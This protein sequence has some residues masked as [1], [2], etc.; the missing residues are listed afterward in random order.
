MPAN[1]L[2]GSVGFVSPP[3]TLGVHYVKQFP[4]RRQCLLAPHGPSDGSH[5]AAARHCF[6]HRHHQQR[7]SVA[8]TVLRSPEVLRLTPPSRASAPTSVVRCVAHPCP[9]ATCAPS[10]TFGTTARDCTARVFPAEASLTCALTGPVTIR[11][12]ARISASDGQEV[13]SEQKGLN[14]FKNKV[15]LRWCGLNAYV[16][17]REGGRGRDR[18][19]ITVHWR[20]ETTAG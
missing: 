4:H 15:R 14:F 1:A 11:D 8:A 9:P 13:F 10:D 3:D 20:V 6:R 5:D 12:L 18:Q 17:C 19:D 2:F 16:Y 7:A